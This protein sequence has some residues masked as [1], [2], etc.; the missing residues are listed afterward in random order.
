M[1]KLINPVTVCMLC[2]AAVI[3]VMVFV[4]CTETRQVATLLRLNL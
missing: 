1:K 2:V 3:G 4:T